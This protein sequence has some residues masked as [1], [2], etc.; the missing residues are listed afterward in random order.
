MDSQTQEWLNQLLA[1]SNQL[2]AEQREEALRQ[3]CSGRE[4]LFD[5]ALQ[6]LKSGQSPTKTMAPA[7]NAQM[8]GPYRVLRE[9]GKGGMG[10]VYLAVRD[11]GAFRKNVAIKLLRGDAVTAEF[12]E[13]FRNERQVLANFDHPNIARILDGGD[14]ADGMPFYVMEYVEGRPIDRYCDEDKLSLNDRLHL[15]QKLCGAIHYLHQNQ[16][17]HRDLKPANI[18]VST[19]GVVKLLDFGIAKQLGPSSLELTTA[20]GTPLT[21][22]YASPEQ[23]TGRADA[24]SDIYTLGV[25]LYLMLTGRLPDQATIKPPS[26]SIREDFQ[27][28]VETT[29]QLK[30]RI[31]GDLDAVVLKSMHRESRQRYGSALEFSEDLDRFLSGQ[32]VLARGGSGLGSKK[33]AIAAVAAITVLGLGGGGYYYTTK[34]QPEAKVQ[35][36]VVEQ[37][38]QQ[39]PLQ[40]QPRPQEPGKEE[41]RKPEPAN[42]NP[43]KQEPL[44]QEPV[45]HEPV[46]SSTVAATQ[47]PRQEAIAQQLPS[48]RPPETTPKTTTQSAPPAPIPEGLE[49]ARDRYASIAGRVAAT[50]Q[51]FNKSK[52]DLEAKGLSIRADTLSR[53]TSMKLNL[54]QAKQDLD[55]GNVAGALKNLTAAE[56]QSVRVSRE[57]GR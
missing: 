42:L 50:E 22:A 34:H 10:V 27:R 11:D 14:T 25:I 19:E 43:A 39:Q 41:P 8:I 53:V 31:M 52:S 32:P 51:L 54:E 16:V 1:Y 7:R 49:E 35:K 2:P 5:V 21:P 23:F 46:R 20:D 33:L 37:P 40:E 57:F 28:T 44:K 3:A 18:L 13:R 6:M 4:D 17:I 24:R 47:A 48:Q 12:I 55:R 15:F 9:L 56:A 26:E 30:K 29:K 36:P 45:K 38:P